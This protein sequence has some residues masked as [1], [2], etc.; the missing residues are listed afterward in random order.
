MATLR[1]MVGI[2]ASGKSTFVKMMAHPE[3]AVVSRD[4][5]RFSL[6]APGIPYFSK[7]TDVFNKFCH[8]VNKSAE[9]HNI[10]WAD[11][12][13][14]TIGSRRKFYNRVDKTLF[15]RLEVYVIN[16]PLED[17]LKNNLNRNGRARVPEDAIRNMHEKF[18]Y[19]TKDEF[20]DIDCVIAE[21][22]FIRNDE[23][24]NE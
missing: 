4:A 20:G 21:I 18:T 3:D 7:E 5:I 14:V 15:D 12:T 10:V 11:A 6:V 24:T 22:E 23:V 16:T 9:S 2:P 13:H 19:P 8:D 1:M 17:C